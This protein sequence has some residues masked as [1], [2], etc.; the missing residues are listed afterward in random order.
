MNINVGGRVGAVA[1]MLASDQSVP[2][3]T[4]GFVILIIPRTRHND[5]STY[6][7]L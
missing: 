4:T 6:S 1:R 2:Y 5:T 3:N 7:G